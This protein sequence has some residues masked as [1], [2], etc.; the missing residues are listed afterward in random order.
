MIP[1]KVIKYH[2]LKYGV[3]I[4]ECINLFEKLE[5]F[6]YETA[7]KRKLVPTKEVDDVWH[8]FIL[9]TQLYELYCKEHF[10]GLIHHNPH[11]PNEKYNCDST[12]TKP[13]IEG[14]DDCDSAFSNNMSLAPCDSPGGLD[15]PG[16]D[17]D[18][19][20]QF[21]PTKILESEYI[22]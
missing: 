13:K 8:T 18:C 20:S 5:M 14:E 3:P 17:N 4:K 9:H 7:E 15:S 2:S 1:K 19:D 10:G 6:F 22:K 12:T 11:M 21:I 16:S